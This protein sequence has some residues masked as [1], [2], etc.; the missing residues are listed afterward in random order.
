MSSLY[1]PSLQQSTA[2]E[3]MLCKCFC[4]IFALD[5]TNRIFEYELTISWES[6][7]TPLSS[8]PG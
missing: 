4:E 6:D 1:M 8:L 7:S 3:A 5:A 2:T